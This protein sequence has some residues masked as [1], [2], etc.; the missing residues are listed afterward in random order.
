MSTHPLPVQMQNIRQS[1]STQA[2]EGFISRMVA[3]HKLQRLQNA[4]TG[5]GGAPVPSEE[6]G[7]MAEGGHL[8]CG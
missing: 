7:I 5:N 8:R 2:I 1:T 3:R 4:Q 6:E